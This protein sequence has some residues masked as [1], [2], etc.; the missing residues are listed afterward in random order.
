MSKILSGRWILTIISGLVFAYSVVTK[1]LAPEAT[2]SIISM[3]FVA[4][5]NKEKNDNNGSDSNSIS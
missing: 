1:H 2:A 4:Y 5:F 3:V